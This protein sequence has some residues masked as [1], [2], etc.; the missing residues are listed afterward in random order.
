MDTWVGD[1]KNP[2][3]LNKY[4]YANADVANGIDPSGNSTMTLSG[5]GASFNIQR[6]LNTMAVVTF[7]YLSLSDDTA[8][9]NS[10][11]N[12]DLHAILA[13]NKV[14]SEV[15]Y[16]AKEL[17]SD[18]ERALAIS[19]SDG[20][21]HAHHT[22]PIFT[23]GA[24]DQSPNMVPLKAS[25]HIALHSSLRAYSEFMDDIYGAAFDNTRSLFDSSSS[26][27]RGGLRTLARTSIGRTYI[28][29][30]LDAFYSTGW[31]A[32]NVYF[33]PRFEAE[34]SLFI[35]NPARNSLPGCQR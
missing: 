29:G 22:I 32:G 14:K 3:T 28:A 30:H 26:I 17:S 34:K 13:H 24:V 11:L 31:Y 15:N 21:W 20:S 25:F 18:V 35:S 16:K 12:N 9:T 2:I 10:A 27:N 1:S 8:A 5:F 6:I 23:C 7:A 4:V 33:K 19:A